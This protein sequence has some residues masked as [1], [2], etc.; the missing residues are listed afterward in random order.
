MAD[1]GLHGLRPVD[2]GVPEIEIEERDALAHEPE[3]LGLG[4]SS[5]E[6]GGLALRGLE[7]RVKGLRFRV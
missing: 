1:D 3:G 7:L 6:L 4:A 5:F 2:V